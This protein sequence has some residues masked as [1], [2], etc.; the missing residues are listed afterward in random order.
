MNRGFVLGVAETNNKGSFRAAIAL[1]VIGIFIL[2]IN[3]QYVYN[4]VR[5]PFPLTPEM[6]DFGGDKEYVSVVG[7]LTF[8]GLMEE[9]THSIRLLKGLV[10]DRSTE[11]SAS[12]FVLDLKD[13]LVVVKTKPNFGGSGVDGKLVPLP[14]NVKAELEVDKLLALTGHELYPMMVDASS[15][16][17][18]GWD[19]NL[20][21][22][23]GILLLG[24]GVIT[25]IATIPRLGNPSRHP[26]FEMVKKY[27]PG[28]AV[29]RRVE[30]EMN[31]L[32]D[33]STVGP[34][35]IGPTWVFNPAKRHPF[36]FHRNDLVAAGT[37]VEPPKKA[38]HTP[39]FS[40]KFWIREHLR[41]VTLEASPLECERVLE[42]LAADQPWVITDDTRVFFQRWSTDRKACVEAMEAL[43]RQKAKEAA[44]TAAPVVHA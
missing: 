6:A 42:R 44:A 20:F 7:K 8:T 28:G 32:G 2:L 38:G 10:E 17:T 33:A 23:I 40:V 13:R 11:A 27:G 34:L 14:G 12:F 21:I 4:T 25:L 31:K 3:H 29:A 24:L 9:K 43:K 36:L 15:D 26:M 39:K 30:D 35:F 16:T 22:P 37:H 1:C 41:P 18:Y 5:G 19:F